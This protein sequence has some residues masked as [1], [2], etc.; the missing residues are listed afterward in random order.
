[1]RLQP[2]MCSGISS[3][4]R[5]LF[6]GFHSTVDAV[7]LQ[8]RMSFPATVGFIGAVEA[9]RSADDERWPTYAARWR[10]CGI[11]QPGALAVHVTSD[12]RGAPRACDD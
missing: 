12:S 4:R 5:F 2:L 3:M 10:A 8:A 1:M 7:F 6:L 9:L 11:M